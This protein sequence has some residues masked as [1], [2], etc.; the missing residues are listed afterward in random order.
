[1]SKLKL[2]APFI[3]LDIE[4]T[5]E[6]AGIILNA[7]IGSVED[8]EK[9]EDPLAVLISKKDV[10]D[11]TTPTFQSH[12][13]K[14]G[15]KQNA[16]SM[17]GTPG[18]RVTTCPKSKNKEPVVPKAEALTSEEYD[19]VMESKNQEGMLS[20]DTANTL[21]LNIREVNA[22]YGSVGYANYLAIRKSI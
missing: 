15:R 2:T 14:K 22:A 16:C 9:E 1:M 17:C 13:N 11:K 5:N 8:E 4:I 6:Q 12:K 18:H 19:S 3:N 10:E 21:G 20:K 7:L